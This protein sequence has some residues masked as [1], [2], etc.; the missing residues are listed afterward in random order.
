MAR[1]RPRKPIAILKTQGT[2]NATRHA[3]R[4]HEPTSGT[5]LTCPDW[6]AGNAR[7]FWD[8]IVPKL[9]A[10]NILDGIDTATLTALAVAWSNWRR[11]Q[12]EYDAGSGHI[13]RLSCAWGMFDKIAS[14]FGLNPVD[15]TKLATAT[16]PDEDDPFTQWLARGGLN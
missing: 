11:E 9:E 6:L 15:R 16:P 5:A 7:D 13:Y 14:K 1:G 8:D 4:E 3:D 2:F 12:A 10:M